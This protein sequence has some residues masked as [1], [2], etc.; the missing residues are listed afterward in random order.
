LGKTRGCH[1]GMPA[2]AVKIIFRNLKSF[3]EFT[4]FFAKNQDFKKTNF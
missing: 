4:S 3:L 2:G 1:Q